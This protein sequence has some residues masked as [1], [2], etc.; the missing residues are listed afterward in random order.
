MCVLWLYELVFEWKYGEC[1]VSLIG[2]VVLLMIDLCMVFVSEILD[3][4]IRYCV[5]VFFV[6]FFL[7]WNMLFVNFGNW[8]V[9]YRIFG[10]MMYGV[11]VLV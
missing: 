11:Y 4:E 1:V 3:V 2:S 9:L 6:L 5:I 10:F 7:M 8:F